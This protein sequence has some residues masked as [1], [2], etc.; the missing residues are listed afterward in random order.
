MLVHGG[1]TTK[2]IHVGVKTE[3]YFTNS[4]VPVIIGEPC[5]VLGVR[6]SKIRASLHNALRENKKIFHEKMKILWRAGRM[7]V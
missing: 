6:G 3:T 1:A 5:S 7:G 4:G 2:K